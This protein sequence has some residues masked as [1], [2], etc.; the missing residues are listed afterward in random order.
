MSDI[1]LRLENFSDTMKAPFHLLRKRFAG[2]EAK[3]NEPNCFWALRNINVEVREG[4]ILGLIG[5]NG[6]GKSTLLKI[7]SQVTE[8]TV[9]HAEIFGRVGSLLEVGTGFHPELTGR[10]NIYL[11]GAVLGMSKREIRDRFDAIVEFSEIETFLETPVKRYSSG[12][13]T[14]LAFAVAAHLDPEILLVDEVL[15]V[16]DA[17]F[18]RKCLGKM[19]EVARGGRTVLFVSHN[20]SAVQRLCQQ[21]IWLEGGT[22]CA[23]GDARAI[24][25]KYLADGD[26]SDRQHHWNNPETAPGNEWVRVRRAGVRPGS[27]AP[28]DPITTASDASIEIEY[29]NLKPDARL[30]TTLHVLSSEGVTVFETGSFESK[31]GLNL[32]SG[33]YRNTCHLPANFLNTGTYHVT[34]LFVDD[35]SRVVFEM[36]NVLTF[37]IVDA[38]VRHSNFHGKRKGLVAPQLDWD[39]QPLGLADGEDDQPAEPLDGREE[40]SPV[41]TAEN[42]QAPWVPGGER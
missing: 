23:I 13:Y 16:G 37:D 22:I 1:A 36:E 7:L 3:R 33:T 15:A 4:E 5:R 8:P 6:A 25:L 31:G 34:L 24:A 26:E 18:Q 35:G 27:A 9:G 2:S 17:K 40:S 42:S 19:G 41:G 21:A 39:V 14:R 30:S 38:A 12:M 32:A 28:E 20:M 10:E 29:E 11:N